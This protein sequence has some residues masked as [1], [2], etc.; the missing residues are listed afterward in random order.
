MHGFFS[1]GDRRGLVA[2]G[3]LGGVFILAGCPTNNQHGVPPPP[4]FLQAYCWGD[5][6]GSEL[7]NDLDSSLNPLPYV[8]SPGQVLSVL[9]MTHPVLAES[10]LGF[11]VTNGDPTGLITGDVDFVDSISDSSESASTSVSSS[12][13][14]T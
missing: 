11:I 9:R 8:T 4:P 5:N 3:A 14:S 2:L 6:S 10:K 13:R 7:G 1:L 12:G